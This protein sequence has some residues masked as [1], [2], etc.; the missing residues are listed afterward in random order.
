MLGRG[1][2]MFSPRNNLMKHFP[3]CVYLHYRNK[4]RRKNGRSWVKSI[5]NK[6]DKL[7]TRNLLS[8]SFYAGMQI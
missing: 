7:G 5:I 2:G 1:K 3:S 8:L 6:L 4:A